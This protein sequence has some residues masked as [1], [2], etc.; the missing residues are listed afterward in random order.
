MRDYCSNCAES[1]LV[2][3]IDTCQ[4]GRSLCYRCMAEHK[5]ATGHSSESDKGRFRVQLN[6][7]F[8][9]RFLSEFDGKISL[10]PEVESSNSLALPQVVQTHIWLHDKYA[11]KQLIDY[12]L[13]RSEYEFL[14]NKFD[15]DKQKVFDYYTS[16][17]TGLL[18]S[19]LAENRPLPLPNKDPKQKTITTSALNYRLAE[20]SPLRYWSS[21][22]FSIVLY[23]IL[24][25]LVI[26]NLFFLKAHCYK[27][28]TT[29][30]R[31]QRGFKNISYD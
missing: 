23:V 16:K 4:C 10:N 21:L 14:I 30:T 29:K 1:F 7:V 6:D 11:R 24:V 15:C 27:G 25:S 3:N 9:K 22:S 31:N 19:F 28:S 8:S 17:V 26:N 20:V 2:E 18:E 12:E 5:H 13:E